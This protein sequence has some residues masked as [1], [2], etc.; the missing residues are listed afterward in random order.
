GEKQG[1]AAYL[2]HRF[3][4]PV[5]QGAGFTEKSVLKEV[6]GIESFLEV[7][8]SPKPLDW[9]IAYEDL[10]ELFSA[11]ESLR[12]LLPQD[13]YYDALFQQLNPLDG[14]YAA[15]RSRTLAA[16]LES[17]NPFAM[18]EQMK[19]AL[20]DVFQKK[21]PKQ[22]VPAFFTACERVNEAYTKWSSREPALLSR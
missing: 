19:Y 9:A 20:P 10:D 6:R 18:P 2:R 12:A 7:D 16:Y 17:G 8:F 14:R 15:S 4:Q 21:N 3:T 11:Y 5:H 22:P 13:A 1:F